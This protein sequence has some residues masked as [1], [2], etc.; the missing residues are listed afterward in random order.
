MITNLRVCGPSFEA[1]FKLPLSPGYTELHFPLFAAVVSEV[2]NSEQM[3]VVVAV[4]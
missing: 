2:S 4:D 3:V 1:L